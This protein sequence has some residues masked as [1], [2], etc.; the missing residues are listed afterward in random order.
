MSIRRS[1]IAAACGALL[2]AG[3]GL[4]PRTAHALAP[5]SCQS[6]A[7]CDDA[8]ACTADTC[9]DGF[10]AHAVVSC[11]DA[12][13]C[14]ADFCGP[15]SGC[16]HTPIASPQCTA[17]AGIPLDGSRLRVDDVGPSRGKRNDVT[18]RDRKL[19]LTGLDPTVTGATAFIGRPSGGAVV[20]VPL[21]AD[22]WAKAGSGPR[23]GYKY[24]SQSGDG[25]FTARLVDGRSIRFSAHGEGLYGLGGEPQGTLAVVVQIGPAAFCGEFGGTVK[26]D[27]GAHFVAVRAPAPPSC[28]SLG[29]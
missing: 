10:C 5:S 16:V 9:D 26:L 23:V 6:D 19:D 22:G 20:A 12:N 8:D 4:L 24:K 13:P 21:P 3:G 1:L 11:D 14:T 28:P 27:D 18:L 7:A 25:V 2:A 17:P 15:G 29:N